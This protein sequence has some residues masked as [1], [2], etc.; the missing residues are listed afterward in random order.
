MNSS[1]DIVDLI[2]SGLWMKIKIIPIPTKNTSEV[3]KI[4]IKTILSFYRLI[5]KAIQIS[6]AFLISSSNFACLNEF[7]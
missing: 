5:Q 1:L 7:I 3:E 2:F 4:Q 6:A